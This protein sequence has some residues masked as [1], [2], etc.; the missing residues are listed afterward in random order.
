MS[1]IPQCNW[2]TLDRSATFY[3]KLVKVQTL[4]L[5]G[6]VELLCNPFNP[7]FVIFRY[8]RQYEWLFRNLLNFFKGRVLAIIVFWIKKKFM[9]HP[10]FSFLKPVSFHCNFR[11]R[12]ANIIKKRLCLRCFRVNFAKFLGT[13]FL[14][15][16]SRRLLL[17]NASNISRLKGTPLFL[18]LLISNIFKGTLMQIWRSPF[19]FV[20]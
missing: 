4:K 18:H 13:L 3:N 7:F 12:P 1:T 19:M 14:Q 2:C 9:W 17:N 11:L 5:I 20:L 6:R 16:T 15:N 10:W 8:L